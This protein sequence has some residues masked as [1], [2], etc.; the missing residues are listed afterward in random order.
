[1]LDLNA[2]PA[3]YVAKYGLPKVAEV[4]GKSV[5]LVSMWIKRNKFPLD[6]ASKLL[7]FDPAPVHEVRPLYELPAPGEKLAILVALTGKPEPKMM[8]CLVKLYN[9]AEMFYERRAFNCTS[10]VRNELAAVGLRSSAKWFFWPDGDSLLPCGDA[11]WYKQAANLPLMPD[12]YAGVHTIHRLLYHKK[13]FV[14][15]CYV[16]RHNDAVP[17][18]G[19]GNT[20]EMR[21]MVRRGPQPLLIERPWSGFGGMLTHRKV[22]EDIIAVMGE[23]I[24][25][26]PNSH[27]AQRFNY[28]YAFFDPLNREVPGDDVPFAS[29]AA[30][31]GHKCYVDLAVQAAHIGDRAFTYADIK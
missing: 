4:V 7:T 9:P 23:E 29:R 15:C 21:Q 22:F 24:R 26:S 30:K 27:I 16:S 13:T 6:A 19:G 31:A 11:A 25:M 1:M 10:V 14:S 28:E 2:L 17:Q 20:P 8:D 12:V 5:S 3:Y 18:F